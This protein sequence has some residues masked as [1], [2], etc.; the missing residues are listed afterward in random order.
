M[1]HQALHRV[2][3]RMLFDPAFARAV[4][5]RPE[6]ALA[7]LGLSAQERAWLAAVDPRAW[8]LDPQRRARSL[9][10]LFDELPASTTLALGELRSRAAL[11]AYFQSPEFHAAMQDR[12]SMTL[13]YADWLA[14]RGLRTPLLPEVLRLER[15]LACCRRELEATPARLASP[16]AGR[17]LGR[18]R[19]G[20]RRRDL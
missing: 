14:G 18:A 3:V 11:D 1:A 2:T 17:P 4:A 6:Q 12:G 16:P 8:T 9:K 7:G 10:A 20:G 15:G 13:A 19:P 5:E